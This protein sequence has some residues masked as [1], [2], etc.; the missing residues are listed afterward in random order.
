[1]KTG[2]PATSHPR[3]IVHGVRFVTANGLVVSPT[4]GI[5]EREG[6]NRTSRETGA[7]E[8]RRSQPASERGDGSRREDWRTAGASQPG[9]RGKERERAG[10]DGVVTGWS[11]PARRGGGRQPGGRSGGASRVGAGTGPVGSGGREPGQEVGTERGREALPFDLQ[12]ALFGEQFSVDRD[13]AV[14]WKTASHS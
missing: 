7:G 10:Q 5:R 2:P 11:R 1:M 14:D 9:R 12:S 8:E 3:C 13:E 4:P 6:R